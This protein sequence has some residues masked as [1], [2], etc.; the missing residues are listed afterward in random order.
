MNKRSTRFY[1][2]N[3]AEVMKQLGFRP[4]KNSGAGWVEKEDGESDHFLCQLKSTDNKS[5]SL[6]QEDIRVLEYHASVSHK[7][8]VFALQFLNTGEVWVMV[9]ADDLDD[10]RAHI[11]GQEMEE[12]EDIFVDNN[13]ETAYNK[14][15]GKEGTQG[16]KQQIRNSVLAREKYK[17]E[18]QQER[19]QQERRYKEKQRE[20][21]E[22]NRNRWKRN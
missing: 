13:E 19:E 9:K 3:E 4:T 2:K 8:P 16:Q 21:K 12:P 20:Q 15:K 14:S 7:W 10:I 18:R 22:R 1:R 6:K 17:Q 5:I 11:Q